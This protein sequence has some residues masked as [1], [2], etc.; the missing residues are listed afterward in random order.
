MPE[1]PTAG[2]RHHLE[3]QRAQRRAGTLKEGEDW[4]LEAYPDSLI[5]ATDTALA[6]FEQVLT[7]TDPESDTAVL[8]AVQHVVLALNAANANHSDAAYD[9][10]EREALCDYIDQALV[11]AGVDTDALTARQGLERWEITDRWRTW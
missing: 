2:W 6:D 7:R 3:E 11:G 5:A 10:D 9:T 8:G 4:A 1:R